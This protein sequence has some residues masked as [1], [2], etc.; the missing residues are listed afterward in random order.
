M[1]SELWLENA[2]QGIDF[3]KGN[4]ASDEIL[5]F[6][7][8]PHLHFHSV[9]TSNKV[10]QHPDHEDL[11][12][13]HVF[14][15][16]AWSIQKVY[17]GGEGHR[18]N[19]EPPLSNP[20]CKSLVGSEKLIFIRSFDDVKDFDP[21]IELSQKL[22][23]ALALHYMDERSAY[24]RLD[25]K[26][27]IEDVISVYRDVNHDPWQQVRAVTIRQHEL[28]TYMALTSSSLFAHFDFTRFASGNFAGWEDTKEDTFE[29]KNLFFR[30]GKMPSHASYAK[31]QII[32]RS[33]LTQD[34]LVEEWKAEENES[35]R[36]YASFMIIDRKN[37]NALVE[38]SCGPDFIVNYFTKSDLPWEVSPAFFR[39]D[40]LLKYKSDPE[41]YT[42][43]DRSISCR[44]SWHLTTYDI[45]DA[46]Q[47]HTYVGYLADLPY[48]EQL[49]WKS[50]NE[51]P[52][53]NISDRAFQTD[54][55]GKFSTTDDPLLDLKDIVRNLDKKPPAWWKPRGSEIIDAVHYPATDSASEWGNEILALDHL[56][57]EGFLVKGLREIIK[58]NGGS[59][60]KNWGSLKI[61]EMGLSL[62]GITDAKAMK[63]VAPL[64]E[65]HTLRNFAKA[66]SNPTERRA[67][68]L[69]AR[70]AHGTLREHFFDLTK[71]L[72]ASYSTI[73]S[74]IFS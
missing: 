63:I 34:D 18:V 33:N 65:L 30:Y 15:A 32:L 29:A 61:M 37:D 2:V 70:K 45:N 31:G 60:E 23:H 4:F 36:Q 47:V 42:F 11:Y 62:S 14:L 19:L 67:A 68:L 41:K 51:P 53:A 38:T 40:V 25:R 66:H 57:T 73:I 64:K 49:Y 44:G 26:G 5:L 28:A 69:N 43:E 13:A 27:D 8:G 50:F 17:G 52:K 16:D 12:L 6:A 58:K 22:V 35:T 72:S 20:G 54:I 1:N 3:L 59:F 48:E 46:G 56:L 10:I 39:S 24:C 55:L 7:S 21:P 74:S 71:R 9:L